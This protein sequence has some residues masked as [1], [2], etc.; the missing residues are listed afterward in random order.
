V[1]LIVVDA[2]VLVALLDANDTL[3]EAAANALAE[4]WDAGARL[5]IPST[6]YA[7]AMVGPL[8]LGGEALALAEAFFASQTIIPIDPAE[9]REAARLRGLHRSWLRLPDALVLATGLLRNAT[10]LT[11]DGRWATV[12]P[13]V[14]VVSAQRPSG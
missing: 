9:G 4:A 6:A 13:L 2:S 3:H 8:E 12:S 11:G 14:Q 10:V 7:E 1:A 5:A